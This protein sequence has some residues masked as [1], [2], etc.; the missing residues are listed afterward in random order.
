MKNKT[1]TRFSSN[2]ALVTLEF[3]A[4][5]LVFVA[6]TC[7]AVVV[8]SYYGYAGS[9]PVFSAGILLTRLFWRQLQKCAPTD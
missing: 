4:S 1:E 7:L 6:M 9:I 2:P 5:F 3:S 8:H